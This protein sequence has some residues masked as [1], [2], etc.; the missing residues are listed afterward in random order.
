MDQLEEI[1]HKT[2]NRLT[3]PRQQVFMALK[4][5]EQPVSLRQIS[6]SVRGAD[7][8][9][10][11]R[12]IELFAQLGVIE[13]VYVGWKKRYELASP[14][15]P[16]HHHLQCTGCQQLIS[17]ITPSLEQLIEQIAESHSYKLTSHHIEL[18]GL[19]LGCQDRP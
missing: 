6:S 7:R 8:T 10:I 2:G 9:S 3:R 5:A 17:I 19:C 12:T 14:F 15:Q 13:I 11:Y 16:H 18:R 4:D 1:L